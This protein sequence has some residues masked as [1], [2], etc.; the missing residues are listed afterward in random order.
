ML[1]KE[2]YIKS[3]ERQKQFIE[4]QLKKLPKESDGSTSYTYVGEI[5][6]EVQEY[7]MDQGFIV[8]KIQN[9][10]LTMMTRGEPVYLFTVSEDSFS[11]TVEEKEE[12]K[13][14]VERDESDKSDYMLGIDIPNEGDF[15]LKGFLHVLGLN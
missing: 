12:A 9:D 13:K 11:L 14:Y 3:V 2:I 15:D 6:H 4:N 10:L 1:G 5:Y 7:F 8:K